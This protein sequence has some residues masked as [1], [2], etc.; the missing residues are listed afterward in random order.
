MPSSSV[1]E[2]PSNVK[3]SLNFGFHADSQSPSLAWSLPESP[4][5]DD[6]TARRVASGALAR[7]PERWH[8][9]LVPQIPPWPDHLRALA[10]ARSWCAARLDVARPAASLRSAALRPAGYPDEWLYGEIRPAGVDVLVATRRR[11][12]PP[13]PTGTG[14]GR[15]LCALGGLDTA[16]GEGA[17]ESRGVIDE[18]YLPP[19]DTWFACLQAGGQRLLLAWI[20]AALEPGVQAAIAVA[21]T[22][23]IAWLGGPHPAFDE[24]RAVAPLLAEAAGLAPG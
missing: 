19:W 4:T 3:V 20:P 22:D 18:C 2:P 16:M 14:E 13:E 10:E 15:I 9:L 24:W 8:G 23:P 11:L 6:T 21:A 5:R 17:A 12:L 7:L 1:F